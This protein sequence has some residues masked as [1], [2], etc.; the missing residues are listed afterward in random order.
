LVEVETGENNNC[1]ANPK[2][3]KVIKKAC[4]WNSA[5]K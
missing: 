3:K 5:W 2:L 1:I 4:A